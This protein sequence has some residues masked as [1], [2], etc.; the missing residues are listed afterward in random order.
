M[1]KRH[2]ITI[3]GDLA[4]GKSSVTDI[5]KKY[6]N[7][8]VYKTGQYVRR[9]ATEKNMTINEFQDYVKIHPEL[10]R[11]IEN[12]SAVYA[13]EHDNIIV[14]ARVGWYAIPYS[15]KV[16]LKTDIDISTKRAYLDRER[17]SSEPCSSIEEVK[18]QII[19][20]NT[21]EI[22]R[23]FNLYNVRKDDM[24]N[25][26]LIIDTSNISVE[27]TAKKIQNAYEEWLKS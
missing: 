1:D 16:Y 3:T 24:K 4:S 8:E 19:S 12:N 26:D 9:L 23:F 14:D 25:Y 10:D 17:K 11:Q 20:R 27:E 2:V 22:D 5:L 21:K 18:N 7:Y 13:E 15:F 6:L